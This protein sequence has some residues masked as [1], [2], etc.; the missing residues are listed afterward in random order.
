MA[1]ASRSQYRQPSAAADAFAI[2]ES[3]DEP[4]TLVNGNAS[5]L[6]A[7]IIIQKHRY[8]QPI[9]RQ[10]NEDHLAPQRAAK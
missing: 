4:E 2:Q 3:I 5:I 10:S 6:C 8:S 7:S 9:F 1:W